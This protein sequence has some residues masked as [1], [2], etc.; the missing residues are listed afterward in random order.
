MES[1]KVKEIKE[2]LQ[3]EYPTVKFL[4]GCIAVI[5]SPDLL[6]D[7]LTLINHQD[8]QIS[9]LKVQVAKL[10]KE[11]KKEQINHLYYRQDSQFKESGIAELEKE[12]T[13]QIKQFAERL[14]EKKV[15]LG[16]R[17]NIYDIDETLKEVINE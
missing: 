8:F 7:C 6:K 10:E 16:E 4:D 2:S 17:F 13:E 3:Q 14:I 9:T 1:E 11:I 12:K 5:V 15:K